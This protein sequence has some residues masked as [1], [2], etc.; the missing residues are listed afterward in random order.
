M[1]GAAGEAFTNT[2]AS[3]GMPPAAVLAREAIQNSVDAKAEEGAKV[4]VDFVARSLA[5]KAKADFVEA[6]GLH[7]LVDRAPVLDLKDPNCFASLSDEKAALGLLFI[8]DY[9][10]TGLEGDPSEPDSKFHRFLLSL[11]DGGK[12]H[13]EHGTGGSYGFGKSV[14]SSNSGILSIFAYSRTKDGNGDPLSILF[15]CGYFRKH[16]HGGAHYTGR[17][18]FGADKS[19]PAGHGQQIVE[20]LRDAEADAAAKLLG[21]AERG[22]DDLGTSVLIVD[23]QVAADDILRG[24]E[25]WWW[26]RILSNQLDVKVVDVDGKATL[27]RPKKRPDLL[28]FI[29]AYFL[30]IGTSPPNGKTDFHKGFNKSE[31]V[32]LG[33]CGFKVLEKNEKD[34]FVVPEERVDAIALVR[35]P[36][37]VVAYHRQWNVQTPAMAGAFV[38]HDDI[39]DILR[40]AEP[41]AHDRWDL[42]ARRL[43]DATGRRRAIVGKV[44]NG[45]KRSL[46][47]CQS[48]ASPPPPPRPK[49]LTLLERTLATFLTPSKKGAPQGPGASAAPIHLSYDAEPRAEALGDKLRLTATFSVRL[50]ADEDVDSI[51]ARVK[52]SCPVIEDGQ[53]GD[54]IALEIASTAELAADTTKEGWSQFD[55]GTKSVRFECKS[56][57][58]DPLWTVR[59]VPEIEPVEETV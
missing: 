51:R 52:V 48:T 16:K 18:W 42:D 57:A 9:N 22:P 15:G 3:S 40:A 27:P 21:F 1:G 53:V 2:L 59:F 34:E 12:E 49:R 35:S 46:K 44:L 32:S 14:Y 28:P 36:K 33:A 26:P 54:S 8:D 43:H 38:G 50:K 58:Y 19:D 55:L 56:E 11:G 23:A 41:P 47:Q 25:D 29:E 37:M 30:A 17:S 39:D 13:D 24:V 7:A 10:T 6:A 5:G 20:P 4:A 31:N 45:I